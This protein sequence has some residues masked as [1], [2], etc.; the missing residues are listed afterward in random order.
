MPVYPIII[1]HLLS[2]FDYYHP[3]FKALSG[4]LEIFTYV[5][6]QR[7]KLFLVGFNL[8]INIGT[9]PYRAPCTHPY[10]SMYR[11]V[12]N[13]IHI[14]AHPRKEPCTHPYRTRKKGM[15]TINL[16]MLRYVLLTDCLAMIPEMSSIISHFSFLQINPDWQSRIC[17]HD[18]RCQWKRLKNNA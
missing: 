4:P 2:I 7:K 10:I 9:N 15:V 3:L 8:F 14:H 11:P 1:K 18:T 17:E 16:A 5:L 6:T 12:H 13:P